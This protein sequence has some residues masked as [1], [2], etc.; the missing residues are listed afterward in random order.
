MRFILWI[1]LALFS[2]NVWADTVVKQGYTAFS[3]IPVLH[4]GRVK[5]LDTLARTLLTNIQGKDVVIDV[6]N[7][8]KLTA[9]QWLAELLFNPQKAYKRPVFNIS[10]PAV[11]QALS[12]PWN[13][14]HTYSFA[15]VTKAVHS[16][17]AMLDALYKMP[18]QKRSIAQ[19][20]LVEIY[21][22]SLKYFEISRSFSLLWRDF[23]VEE[24][25][26]TKLLNISEN[27]PLNY[28]DMLKYKG[29][30]NA[31]AAKI[32]GKTAE[33]LTDNEK[34]VVE[35]WYALEVRAKDT[36][37]KGLA[38]I[39][40][41]WSGTNWHAPWE[42]LQ[43]GQGSPD[44]AKYMQIWGGLAEQ[45]HNLSA[46]HMMVPQVQE[47]AYTMVGEN[48][49][50]ELLKLEVWYNSLKPFKISLILYVMSFICLLFS[51]IFWRNIWKKTA[52]TALVAGGM[53]NLAGIIMR[54]IIMQRP[55]VATLYESIIFVA[56][57]AVIF[58]IIMEYKKR[59]SSSTLIGALLGS[60]LQFIAMRYALEGDT[61]GMLSAVL[62][63]NFWLATHVVTI[64]IGYGCC[65][66]GGVLG[67]V[68]LVQRF[69]G[70]KTKWL[71]DLAKKMLAVSLVALFFSILGTILGGIWAD[72]SWGRFWGWDPKENGAMFI[73]LWL[74]WLVHG[75]ITKIIKP[76][77]LA[78]G[79]V[80]TNI[81]VALAWFG[82]N[83]LGVGLHSYGFTE[84]IAF[85]LAAFC[86]AEI[87]FIA[88]VCG[89]IFYR[90]KQCKN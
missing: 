80:L 70:Y 56:L 29:I 15:S 69:L 14:K 59:D 7:K 66:V 71:N 82:V 89:M 63:T 76:F 39:P 79:M 47:V 20:Q 85:N 10:N 4:E 77:G 51:M 36:E 35:L 44:T 24:K 33:E 88:V 55:P 67:H 2:T 13:E 84:G 12:L 50:P 32:R 19:Q 43:T 30:L 57:V 58:A 11:L 61:L 87:L 90:E 26:L 73:C 22:K 65:L 64:T 40:P 68:Y 75:R 41:Q 42:V 5:P 21:L 46:W 3:S 8:Q 18:K 72:Q 54:I 62:N 48:A 27:K 60:V 31:E 16:Q 81:A 37:N 86:G 6:K 74:I 78:M 23:E 83:L 53:M 25:Y 1:L 45:Y 17:F 52:F 34:A 28:M 49:S 38:I 9:T